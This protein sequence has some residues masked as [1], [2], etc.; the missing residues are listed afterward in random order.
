VPP[1]PRH[2]VFSGRVNTRPHSLVVERIWF[3][4]VANL[5]SDCC[6]SCHTGARKEEPLGVE[7][8]VCIL[9]QVKIVGGFTCSDR[10]FKVATL[11]IGVEHNDARGVG[12]FKVVKVLGLPMLGELGKPEINFPL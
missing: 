10:L 5:E 8:R 3:D 11:E 12:D 2:L 6:A 4:Q 9:L 7:G 1:K